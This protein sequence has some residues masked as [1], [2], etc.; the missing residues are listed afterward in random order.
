[1]P[2]SKLINTMVIALFIIFGAFTVF[3]EEKDANYFDLG[4]FSY[5]SGD[6]EKAETQLNG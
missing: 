3:A 2:T 4:V 5:E 6:Y 1:M